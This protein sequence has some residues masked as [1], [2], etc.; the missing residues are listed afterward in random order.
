MNVYLPPDL[1]S[2]SRLA[3]PS[4]SFWTQGQTICFFKTS[5]TCFFSSPPLLVS[6]PSQVITNSDHYDQSRGY[7]WHIP[8]AVRTDCSSALHLVQ[9]SSSFSASSSN[10][11]THFTQI[12]CLLSFFKYHCLTYL[13][14]EFLTRFFP[15]ERWIGPTSA[16]SYFF[17]K[18]FMKR[19]ALA[20]IL[21]WHRSGRPRVS[22]LS[23]LSLWS[24]CG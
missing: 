11:W 15:H 4:S 6:K 24:F 7:L 16:I 5:A 12:K 23:Q 13:P 8:S 1:S 19:Q 22:P 3:L 14:L 21:P 10:G 9:N 17:W 20:S 18:Y 2:S